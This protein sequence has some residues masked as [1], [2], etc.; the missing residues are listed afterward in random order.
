MKRR[1]LPILLSIAMVMSSVSVY[2]EDLNEVIEEVCEDNEETVEETSEETSEEVTGEE[3]SDG[4][5]VEEQSYETEELVLTVTE[6]SAEPET[7]E[8]PAE[9]TVTVDEV[10][11]LEEVPAI[12]GEVAVTEAVAI[13]EEVAASEETVAE[14]ESAAPVEA[15]EAE[16]VAVTEE[17]ATEEE[18]AVP[19]ETEVEATASEVKAEEASVIEETEKKE[20]VKEETVKEEIV[21]VEETQPEEKPVVKEKTDAGSVSQGANGNVVS[22]ASQGAKSIKADDKNASLFTDSFREKIQGIDDTYTKTVENISTSASSTGRYNVSFTLK[23]KN[24]RTGIEKTYLYTVSGFLNEERANEYVESICATNHTSGDLQFIYKNPE[25]IDAEKRPWKYDGFGDVLAPYDSQLCWAGSTSDMLQL[26]GWNKAALI[27]TYGKDYDLADEDSLFDLFANNYTDMAGNQIYGVEWFFNGI[28]RPQE[29]ENWSH[30]KDERGYT[31]GFLR[32]YYVSDFVKSINDLSTEEKLSKVLKYIDKDEDGDRCALGLV[33]GYYE[34]NSKGEI[35]RNG[36]HCVTI[37]GYSTDE[38]GIPN[39]ITIADSDSYNIVSRD[40]YYSEYYSRK[41]YNNMY[42]TYPIKFFDG[43]WHLMNFTNDSCDTRIDDLITLKYYGDNT[44]NNIEQ[45]GTKDLVNYFDF[46]ISNVLTFQD[47]I[48]KIVDTVYQG[49]LLNAGFVLRDNSIC[50]D[51]YVDIL[52]YRFIIS[53]DGEVVKVMDYAYNAKEEGDN[54]VGY[55]FFE[56]IMDDTT[57]LEPGEYSISFIINYDKSVA[58]AYYKNNQSKNSLKF[59]VLKR[60]DENGEAHYAVVPEEAVKESKQEEP[61]ESIVDFIQ[62]IFDFSIVTDTLEYE[63]DPEKSLIFHLP[64]IM[65]GTDI[66][67]TDIVAAEIV[68]DYTVTG[69]IEKANGAFGGQITSNIA[70]T[71]DDFT[72]IKNADGSLN[73]VFSNAFMR[74]LPKGTHYFRMLI[75]GKSQIFKIEIK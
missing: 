56:N 49:D 47:D 37:V 20:T 69:E 28:N 5:A 13:E 34:E 26:S 39:T 66:S 12:E 59:V 23:E 8:K 64:E 27:N 72:I 62:N 74:K 41:D 44:K 36:G 30:L 42:T 61:E 46:Y 24:D 63:K 57:S 75:A 45:D 65:S 21:T 43:E 35:E 9:E 16:E 14:E 58:E 31:E 70:I 32:D 71:K 68:F 11:S 4:E 48:F 19:E 50:K 2:A 54:G 40:P 29:W 53:K 22:Q 6:V 33:F 52:P 17:A 38:N 51:N 55:I 10:T 18:A 60:I 1:L 73:I 25:L 15:V 67:D 3:A 7:E